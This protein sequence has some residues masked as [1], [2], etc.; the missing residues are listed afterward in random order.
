MGA[1]RP[2]SHFVVRR[3]GSLRRSVSRNPSV[4]S[5]LCRSAARAPAFTLIELLVV[6]SIIALLIGILLPALSKAREQ[7]R[8]LKCLTNLK[9]LG[10]SMA[11]YFND[12]NATLPYISPIAGAD[13]NENSTDMFEVL[14]AYIDAPR[15]HHE[16]PG[17]ETSDWVSF[18]PYQCPADRGGTDPDDPRPA[19]ARYG[20]SYAYPAA[21]IYV[22]LEFLGAIDPGN[23]DPKVAAAEK[24]KGARAVSTTYDTYANQGRK[25]AIILDLDGWHPNPS[26]KN[27]LFWDG[28]ADNYPGD[29]PEGFTQQFLSTVIQLCGFGG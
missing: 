3:G 8:S 16:V 21:D 28:S 17:D 27:A 11:L 18:D 4:P 19:Y 10:T 25:L 24:W 22:A 9:G 12:S 15:P 26:G 29:P 2:P 6:I 14:D 13:E 5:S 7:S 1:S 20:M 23:A